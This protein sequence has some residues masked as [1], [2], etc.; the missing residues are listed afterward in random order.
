MHPLKF[1]HTEVSLCAAHK[2]EGALA[3]ASA[4]GYGLQERT[5]HPTAAIRPHSRNRSKSG[6]SMRTRRC[7]WRAHNRHLPRHDKRRLPKR[8][9]ADLDGSALNLPTQR[10]PRGGAARPAEVHA[11]RVQ[12]AIAV[13]NC[14]RE[15]ATAETRPCFQRHGLPICFRALVHYVTHRREQNEMVRL[16]V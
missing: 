1:G 2:R 14:V 12:T 16:V 15:D 3:S 11:H 6:P 10:Q 4:R 13:R 8:A 7:K 5:R 9:A